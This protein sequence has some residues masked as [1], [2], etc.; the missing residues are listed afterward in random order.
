MNKK[1]NTIVWITGIILLIGL[2]LLTPILAYKSVSEETIKIDDKERI[3]DGQSSYYL[4]FTDKGV[5]KNTDSLLFFKFDS[6]DIYNE[7]KIG[8]TYKVKINWYR[9]RFLN[10]YKN[11]LE[12]QKEV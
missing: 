2:I 12:I 8:N 1:G 5:F 10:M 4:I 11:I 9:I 7:L 3:Q 6:S